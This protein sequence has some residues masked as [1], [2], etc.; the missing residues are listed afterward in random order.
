MHEGG[1]AVVSRVE[2]AGH[3]MDITVCPHGGGWHR[4]RLSPMTTVATDGALTISTAESAVA[5]LI[6]R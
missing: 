6:S 3:H 1:L 2:S 4:L 5:G